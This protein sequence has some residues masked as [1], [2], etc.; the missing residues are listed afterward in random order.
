MLVQFHLSVDLQDDKIE[1]VNL[2][3]DAEDSRVNEAV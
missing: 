3:L 2:L 1:R